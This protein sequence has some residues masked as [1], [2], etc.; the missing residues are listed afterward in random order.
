MDKEVDFAI[1]LNE[2]LQIKPNSGLI[3]GVVA[4]CCR[5]EKIEDPLMKKI[6]Y[7]DKL[8]DELV[9]GKKIERILKRLVG[10]LLK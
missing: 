10:V 5:V 3:K 7:L 6:R 1:F 9:K 4:C 8:V 2:V